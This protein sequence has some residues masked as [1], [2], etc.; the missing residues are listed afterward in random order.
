MPT[1]TTLDRQ[2]TTNISVDPIKKNGTNSFPNA[3][4]VVIAAV[5]RASVLE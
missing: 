1:S 2:R 5:S 3:A 4:V